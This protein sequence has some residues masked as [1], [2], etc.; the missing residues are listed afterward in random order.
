M[1]G[2]APL[3]SAYL[4]PGQSIN[5]SAYNTYSG[6]PTVAWGAAPAPDAAS[7]YASPQQPNYQELA[8]A[9]W[10]QK[11]QLAEA[12][13]EAQARSQ[14]LELELAHRER[15]QLWL[16]YPVVLWAICVFCRTPIF[17]PTVTWQKVLPFNS[18]KRQTDRQADS[19]RDGQSRTET[20][21]QS[22]GHSTTPGHSMY[23]NLHHKS[24][25][26][27]DPSTIMTTLSS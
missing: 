20:E 1:P 23:L 24:S 15:G 8:A 14:A 27:V 4:L 2:H 11:R 17:A 22:S 16:P 12:L 19:D 26:V 10:E 5:G 9:E 13:Q 21:T 6:T 3:H 18:K 7:Q 25:V